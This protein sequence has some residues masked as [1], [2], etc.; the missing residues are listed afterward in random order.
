MCILAIGEVPLSPLEN[1]FDGMLTLMAY[2]YAFNLT[3]PKCIA[4]LLS[5]IQTEVLFDE[6]HDHDAHKGIQ[7]HYD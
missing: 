7:K 6:I 2:Y 3:Y 5:D 1:V 4:T